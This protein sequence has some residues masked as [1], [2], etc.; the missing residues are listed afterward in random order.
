MGGASG[1]FYFGDFVWRGRRLIGEA[2]GL[3]EYGG[4]EREIRA[5]LAAERHRQRDLEDAG[6]KVHRWD[7]REAPKTWL[8]RLHRALGGPSH[9]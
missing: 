7:T 4:A 5:A 2:D 8:A 3:G 6:W 9:P 1:R